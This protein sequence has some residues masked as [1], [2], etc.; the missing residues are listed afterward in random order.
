VTILPS[1][2]LRDGKVVRLKQ[3]DY[4]RQINYSVDPIDTVRSFREAGKFR[5]T[6]NS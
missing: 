1:I 4:G 5:P 6:S 3:G 2:D